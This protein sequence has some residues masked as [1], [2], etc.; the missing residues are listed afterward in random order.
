MKHLLSILVLCF[1]STLTLVSSDSIYE[2]VADVGINEA[3]DSVYQE[4]EQRNFYVIF[5]ANIGKNISRF[6]E[7]WG[8]NYNKNNLAGIRGMV[9][10]NGW[11]ANK[12]SNKD[13]SMLAPCPTLNNHPAFS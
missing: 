10:C 2:K 4:L 5:E 7:K 11:Y 9:F 6:K 8:E 13:P 12:V 1:A 3:F